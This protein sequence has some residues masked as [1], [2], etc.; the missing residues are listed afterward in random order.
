MVVVPFSAILQGLLA[1]PTRKGRARTCQMIHEVDVA[2][3]EAVSQS[4]CAPTGE[5]GQLFMLVPVDESLLEE[6]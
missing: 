4:N 3:L 5:G 2:G 6:W 1:R